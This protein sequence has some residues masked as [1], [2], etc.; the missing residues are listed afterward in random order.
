MKRANHFIVAGRIL[1]VLV[2]FSFALCIPAAHAQGTLSDYQRSQGLREKLQGLAINVPGQTNWVSGTNRFWYRKSVRGGFEYVLVDADALTKQPAFDHEKLAAAL[3]S[4]SGAKYTAITLPFAEAPAGRGGGRGAQGAGASAF[5]FTDQGHAIEFTLAGFNW[6]CDLSAYECTKG[7]AVPQVAFGGRG[8]RGPVDESFADSVAPE[9]DLLASPSM[10]DAD[11]RDGIENLAPQSSPQQGQGGRGGVGPNGQPIETA[12]TSPDGNWDALIENYNVFLRRKGQTEATPLS[13]DGSEGNYYT[14]RSI[15]WSPDSKHLVAY[16]TRPGYQR[17]VHYVESSPADQVQPKHFTVVYAKPGDTLDVARPTLFEVDTKKEIQID[18][19]LFP[20]AFDITLPVWWKD[21]R[22]FTFE[23]N[24]R[25]HQLYRV[26]EVDAQTGKARA[27]ITEESKTFIDYRPLAE[28]RTDTGKKFRQNL[29]DGSEIIWASERDGW[30]H[31]YLFDGATG[32]LKNQITKGNWIV[33]YVDFVDEAKRQI[34]FRASGMVPGQDPYFTHYYRINFDGTGLT[35]FTDADGDYTV[36]FSE[37]RKYYVDVWSRVDQAPVS[38]L[39]R[40][41]DHKVLMELEHADISALVA[42]GWK[43]PEVFVAK[44]RDG[45]TDIWGVIYRPSNFDPSKK[46]PVI[47]TI[48]AG[49]QGSFVPKTFSGAA[50]PLAELGFIVV[51]MDG[52][53]TNNR[54]RAFHDVAFQNLGDAGFPDRILWHKA[55]AAKY[56]W[57]DITRVG[58]YGTSAGGQSSLGG[59]LFH[60][61]FYKAA[62]SNS[63]CHD[64]RMDKI[65]WNEQWMGWP[66]GPQYSASSNV[67][68]AERLQGKLMLVLGELDNNVDPSSTLQVVNQMIKHDKKFDLLFVPGGGHGAGG[69]YGQ[70]LLQDFFVHNLLGVEPPEWKLLEQPAPRAGASS[71]PSAQ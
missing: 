7:A 20:N 17:E 3:S 28:N 65:W 35:A 22:A 30:E 15:V 42:A 49:P 37:D 68:N 26:I 23:Y 19:A 60:P 36:R 8:G 10:L 39:R 31:L 14:L 38:Q 66:I 50:Q 29:G 47:E 71:S 58:I 69:A 2:L 43:P 5:T 33:R 46:Y 16:R 21:S 13:L 44:A 9:D 70:H 56:P 52:M 11:P 4:A 57:Y 59:L 53:G 41:D 64:N 51:Q 25:G 54:S 63:G 55:V 48:Y 45:A 6:K 12:R 67:D 61:E 27:V 62:V 40:T 32:K 1:S 18:D 34:W 24:Q